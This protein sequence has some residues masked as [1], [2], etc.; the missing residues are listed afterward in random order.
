MFVVYIYWFMHM[1]YRSFMAGRWSS[2]GQ[3][4]SRLRKHGLPLHTRTPLITSTTPTAA[5]TSTL[6]GHPPYTQEFVMIPNPG[7]VEPG[8]QASFPP[9]PSLSP[10]PSLG[11]KARTSL[12]RGSTLTLSPTP[13]QPGLQGAQAHHPH[14]YKTPQ[15]NAW[16]SDMTVNPSKY[17]I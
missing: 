17:Q 8:S 4:R 16:S 9:K 13:G 7:H 12:V 1:L 2:S 11:H 6:L 10:P 3:G 15:T 5:T 14:L